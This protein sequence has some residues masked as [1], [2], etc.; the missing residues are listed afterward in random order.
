[1]DFRVAVREIQS[2]DRLCLVGLRFVL[3]LNELFLPIRK[4]RASRR[5][6]ACEGLFHEGM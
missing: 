3:S 2:I 4:K 6:Y 1:M 5:A